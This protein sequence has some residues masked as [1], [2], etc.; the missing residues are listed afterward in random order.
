MHYI[1]ISRF[2]RMKK[3]KKKTKKKKIRRRMKSF[4]AEL[5]AVAVVGALKCCMQSVCNIVSGQ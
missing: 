5:D 4:V 1:A 3:K 2:R